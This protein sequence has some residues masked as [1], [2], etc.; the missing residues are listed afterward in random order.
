MLQVLCPV[1]SFGSVQLN[2][3]SPRGGFHV[4]VLGC[5]W[6]GFS[7]RLLKKIDCGGFT[8]WRLGVALWCSLVFHACWGEDVLL[9][10]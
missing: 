5:V 9:K 3:S 4:A 10:C 7:V 1:G 2:L 8:P 6:R